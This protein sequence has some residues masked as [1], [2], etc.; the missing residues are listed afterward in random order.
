MWDKLKDYFLS[1]VVTKYAPVGV[2]AAFSAFCTYLAA[3]AGMFEPY[4]I[5]YGTWPLTWAS[6]QSPS[7]PVI[8]IE[9]DTIKASVLVLI[10]TVI[11]IF[12]RVGEHHVV[13][14]ILQKKAELAITAATP[15]EAV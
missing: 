14:P 13:K 2:I 11:A 10:P 6:G 3:H 5:T 1:A 15:K 12:S 4:G 9:L 7:G 8:L